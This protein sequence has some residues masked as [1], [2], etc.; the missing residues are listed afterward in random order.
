MIRVLVV[1]DS[2][3]VRRLVVDALAG[4]P[5]I[6]VV[7]TTANGRVALAMVD[8][9]SPDVVT[10]DIEMPLMD[11]I[12]AIRALRRRGNRCRIIIFTKTSDQNAKATFAALAAGATEFVTKPSSVISENATVGMLGGSL[13]QK[14]KA[15]VQT[16]SATTTERR[17]GVGTAD[18]RTAYGISLAEQPPSRGRPLR[19]V[20]IGTS[21]GGPEALLRVL[22]RLPR[23]P[24]PVAVVQHMPPVFTRQLAEW[25]NLVCASTVLES[26]G[27]EE[28]QPGH[29]YVAQGDYHLEVR[30]ATRGAET[31]VQQDPPVN[32]TRPSIDVLFR[33]AARVY[34]GDLLAVLLT[35][36][37]NDGLAGCREVVAA[38]GTVIVQDEASSLAW[39]MPGAV[40]KAG[41]A[42][43]VLLLDEIGPA[44]VA[45][46]QRHRVVGLA[47]TEGQG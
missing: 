35:G 1:D 9:M 18:V 43:H 36:M 32:S 40:A 25:L 11:G 24:V 45:T 44:I 37:G 17:L 28:L 15:V 21:M 5:E 7:G 38:G 27:R 29:V 8:E 6:E 46:A 33:S 31:L 4:D 16:G 42:H 47:S 30:A 20:V 3:V 22:R 14:I 34:G 2:A 10:M 12:E 19:A 39:G 41:L 23:L 13:I 26:T